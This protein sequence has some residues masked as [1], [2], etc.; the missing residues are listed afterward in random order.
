[1]MV[2]CK[3]QA[4]GFSC[5]ISDLCQDK[6]KFIV[7]ILPQFQDSSYSHPSLERQKSRCSTGGGSYV[8][9]SNTSTLPRPNHSRVSEE[10]LVLSCQVSRQKISSCSLFPLRLIWQENYVKSHINHLFWNFWD[11][12]CICNRF[13]QSV[14][15]RH[16]EIHT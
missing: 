10:C 4:E 1:M 8:R 12:A 16:F 6:T 3:M 7:V 5:N 11:A 13:C 2:T 15:S 14:L 9:F